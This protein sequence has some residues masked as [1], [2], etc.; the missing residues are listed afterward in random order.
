VLCLWCV[1]GKWDI[2][3]VEGKNTMSTTSHKSRT[4][5]LSEAAMQGRKHTSREERDL[6]G[7]GL[8]THHNES[9]L[10]KVRDKVQRIKAQTR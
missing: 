3:I 7:D 5:L 1:V 10:H 9:R 4:R 6:T 2:L 8:D